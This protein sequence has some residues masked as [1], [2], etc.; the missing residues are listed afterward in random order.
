MLGQSLLLGSSRHFYIPC[1]RPVPLRLTRHI[2]FFSNMADQPP[3]S[4]PQYGRIPSLKNFLPL[5][6]DA[7]MSTRG[8]HLPSLLQ[9]SLS[10]RGP[11]QRP[12]SV[13]S[14]DLYSE[15]SKGSAPATPGLN[16]DR[17]SSISGV[18]VLL[19]PQMRSQRLI[20]NSNPRYKW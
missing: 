13:R 15:P 19:T 7:I 8:Q 10:N 16:D 4:P 5:S 20:G 18:S 1:K 2:A 9:Q 6:E 11:S 17:R 14:E 3:A 12:S